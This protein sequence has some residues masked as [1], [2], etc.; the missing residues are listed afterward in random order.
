MLTTKYPDLKG[1]IEFI[2]P[3]LVKIDAH[4]LISRA[5]PN[6]EIIAADFNRGL[7]DITHDGTVAKI[8]KSM[9]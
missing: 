8:M 7:K 5:I 1:Q 4:N 2:E 6:Y 3:A 9:I